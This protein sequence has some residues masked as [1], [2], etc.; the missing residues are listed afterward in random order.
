[1]FISTDDDGEVKLS[2]WAYDFENC[3]DEIKPIP[4]VPS[5][6]LKHTAFQNWIYGI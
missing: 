2:W 4:H 3:G 5:I 1:M 6:L